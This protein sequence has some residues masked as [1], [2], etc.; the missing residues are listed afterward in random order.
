MLNAVNGSAVPHFKITETPTYDPSGHGIAQNNLYKS[1]PFPS[2]ASFC[3]A[4]VDYSPAGLA[5]CNFPGNPLTDEYGTGL[6]NPI[7]SPTQVTNL[8]NGLPIIGAPE[9]AAHTVPGSTSCTAAREAA[10][11]SATRPR[12]TARK[13][14]RTTRA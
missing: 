12:H 1:Q 5:K 10:A 3:M 6:G 4:I 11:S 13:R 14:T 9:S 7:N 8:A 2:G